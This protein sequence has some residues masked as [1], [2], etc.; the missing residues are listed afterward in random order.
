MVLDLLLTQRPWRSYLAIAYLHFLI[1][2][3]EIAYL[4]LLK[5]NAD[6]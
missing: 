1:C 3:K 2:Q 4:A 6:K 5:L